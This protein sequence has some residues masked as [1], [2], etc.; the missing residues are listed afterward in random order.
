MQFSHHFALKALL[1]LVDDARSLT[2]WRWRRCF[3]TSHQFIAGPHRWHN[4]RTHSQPYM[5]IQSCQ[6]AWCSL[7]LRTVAGSCGTRS[8]TDLKSPS[9]NNLVSLRQIYNVLNVTIHPTCCHPGRHARHE[10]L[11]LVASQVIV[12]RDGFRLDAGD[13]ISKKTKCFGVIWRIFNKTFWFYEI[14][15]KVLGIDLIGQ[16]NRT[17]LSLWFVM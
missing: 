10:G 5:S 17:K 9:G 13:V 7:S 1:T 2:D 16:M 3:W 4:N 6:S 15:K 8:E 14:F 11:K 12:N